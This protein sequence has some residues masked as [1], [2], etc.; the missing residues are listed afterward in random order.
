M[1]LSTID[2]GTNTILMVTLEM[3]HDGSMRLVS[4]QHEIARLGKGVDASRR[5]QPDAFDRVAGYLEGYRES[6]IQLG[7]DQ[8]VAFGTS[9]LRDA[10][11]RDEFCRA[12]RERTGV[13]IEIL[14]GDEE[15]ELTYHGALFGMDFSTDD[16]AVLDIGGGSTELAVGRDGRFLHGGSVDVGA[17]RITER[18]LSTAPVDAATIEIAR[19]YARDIL[20]TFI[21][22]P[23]STTVVGVAGTVT[24]LGAIAADI[25]EFNPTL[26]DGFSLSSRAIHAITERLS[27]LSVD[28]IR[29]IPQVH[30]ERADLLLGGAIILDE[31]VAINSVAE[32]IV[33]TR[34]VRYGY[35]ERRLRQ[36]VG[37]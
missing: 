1:I 22:L 5:I 25:A 16:C 33:S 21:P 26:L 29:R 34:G 23:N 28:E 4:D 18:H 35:A 10:T 13:S 36:E 20:G 32:V 11:N 37:G 14:T 24:T 3:L 12:M 6:A 8:I 7:A 31:F 17:V 2:I 27:T 30:P 9:A 15:A 19:R